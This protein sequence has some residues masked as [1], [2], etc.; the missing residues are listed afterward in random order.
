MGT[1]RNAGL[2]ACH[3]LPGL[4][5]G[6]DGIDARFGL[7]LA[8]GIAPV[9]AWRP[10]TTARRVRR[11]WLAGRNRVEPRCRAASPRWR[12]WIAGTLIVTHT[13]LPSEYRGGLSECG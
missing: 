3:D 7:H 11:P 4:G 13:C 1:R 5:R 9:S 8:A 6:R 12:S 10:R 2:G